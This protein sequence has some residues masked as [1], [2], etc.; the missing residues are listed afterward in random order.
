MVLG[1][2]L[3][4]LGWAGP[5]NADPPGNNGTI[6]IDGIRFDSHPDNEPHVG[7]SFQIDFYGYE[8]N[9]PVAM[10]FAVQ[11]PTGFAVIYTE[12]GTLDDD[13]AT[14]GGSEAGLDGSFT[15]ELTDALAGYEPPNHVKLT[16]V[17]DDGNPNGAR[18]KH[19]VFWVTDCTG[20]TTTT[21]STTTTTTTTTTTPTTTTLPITTLP[22]TTLPTTTPPIATVGATATG[23]ATTTTGAATSAVTTTE[24]AAQ[25]T[26][27][28]AANE[29][30]EVLGI[31]ELPSTG[32][33]GTLLVVGPALVLLGLAVELLPQVTKRRRTVT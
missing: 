23:G 10:V 31:A 8:A 1:A 2:V 17:T 33:S 9:T 3:L 16:V 24:G 27:V 21:T 30:P 5:A 26:Q 18:V 13:D 12:T 22:I 11:P 14:G 15:I 29:N 28:P 32:F 19:K 25:A 20:G 4:V 7:C 6:K